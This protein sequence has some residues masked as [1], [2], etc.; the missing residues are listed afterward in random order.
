MYTV[1]AHKDTGLEFGNVTDN[2][3]YKTLLN[4]KRTDINL[5]GKLGFTA[6]DYACRDNGYLP[7]VNY[8]INHGAKI[9]TTTMK[10]A[11]EGFSK[12]KGRKIIY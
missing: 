11:I 10:C 7:T 9:L 12:Y 2:E 1:G 8:L 6:L 4:D 5:T 3:N